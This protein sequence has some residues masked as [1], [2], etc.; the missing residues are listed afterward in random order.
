[1]EAEF[2][3]DAFDDLHAYEIETA[4]V[5]PELLVV[6]Q[7]A[8]VM[9]TWHLY[10]WHMGLHLMHLRQ[11]DVATEHATG[12]PYVASE[13]S[14]RAHKHAGYVSGDRD[15]SLSSSSRKM[16]RAQETIADSVKF[17]TNRKAS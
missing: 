5:S 8:C 10:V 4:V 6:F 2:M 11:L 16:T 7:A 12:R 9:W 13:E 3:S 1:M 17:G 14:K 15:R